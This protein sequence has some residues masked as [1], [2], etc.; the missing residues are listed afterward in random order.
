MEIVYAPWLRAETMVR[1]GLAFAAFPYA[2][3][4]ARSQYADF[5]MAIT[6]SANPPRIF[7]YAPLVPTTSSLSFDQLIQ[8]RV[9]TYLGYFVKE[10]LDEKGVDYVLAQTEEKAFEML[11]KG[12]IDYL[13]ADPESGWNIIQSRFS[14]HADAFGLLP[15][16]FPGTSLHL[17]V[18][19]E[20]PNASSILA[21]CNQGFKAMI[22]DGTYYQF[23][24]TQ[25]K[26][27][28]AVDP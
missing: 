27:D 20:Y 4:E 8:Y 7:Y 14:E 5:S 19:R 3:T 28:Y 1:H 21:K 18:S 25:D 10:K 12:R 23:L 22:E 17:M 11:Q 24:T 15:D 26:S 9:G 2:I 16:P 13:P 6:K